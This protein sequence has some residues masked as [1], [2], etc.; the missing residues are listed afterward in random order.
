[1]RFENVE[2]TW[3]IDPPYQF[4]GQHYKAVIKILI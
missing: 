2:A 1:M 3:F 4:G